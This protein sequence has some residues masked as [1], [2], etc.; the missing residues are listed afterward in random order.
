MKIETPFKTSDEKNKVN[1]SQEIQRL[2][3]LV[4]ELASS[5]RILIYIRDPLKSAVSLLS[6][7]IKGGGSWVGLPSPQQGGEVDAVS[8]KGGMAAA[9]T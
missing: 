6:T 8:E 1:L 9:G 2:K 4:E 7:A 5:I 3:K